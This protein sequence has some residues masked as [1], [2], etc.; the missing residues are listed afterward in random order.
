SILSADFSRLGE[1]VV[2]VVEAGADYIHIDVMDGHFVP[3]ITVGPLVVEAVRK[4]TKVPLDVHLMIDSPERYVGQFAEAGADIIT[5][6][7]EACPHLHRVVQLIRSLG[8]RP[9]VSLNPATPLVMIEEILPVVGLVLV[10]SVNPGF[11]GQTFIPEVIGKIRTLRRMLDDRRLEV[12]LEVDGGVG[13]NN[14][15]D[16]VIAGASVLVAGAAIFNGKESPAKELSKL[17]KAV[18]G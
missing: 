1:Q 13:P 9:G 3:N 17:R 11:G 8:V 2:E 6:H 16:V 7:V 4:L 12:E 5:V 18:G 10:M 14:A 15:A